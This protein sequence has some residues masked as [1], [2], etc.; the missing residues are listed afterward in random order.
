MSLSYLRANGH[1]QADTH[2]RESQRFELMYTLQGKLDQHAT[3]IPHSVRVWSQ[4]IHMSRD[5]RISTFR[6]IPTRSK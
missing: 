4:T 5:Q 1:K 2:I 6:I 3:R